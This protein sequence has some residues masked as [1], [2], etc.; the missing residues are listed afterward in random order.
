MLFQNLVEMTKRNST[1]GS[2]TIEVAINGFKD[3][4][5]GKGA[6]LRSLAQL[7]NLREDRASL[8]P[9]ILELR[10]KFLHLSPKVIEIHLMAGRK[11]IHVA[12]ACTINTISVACVLRR[13]RSLT[14][15][16]IR[17]ANL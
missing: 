12:S 13:R 3:L 11:D 2:H 17:V 9:I 10:A 4:T 14:R 6:I 5:H 1:V 7:S 8:L 16:L 15:Y